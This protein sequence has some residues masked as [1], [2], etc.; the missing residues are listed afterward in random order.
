MSKSSV[1]LTQSPFI[2]KI[3]L[4]KGVLF[5]KASFLSYALSSG[6]VV[7]ICSTNPIT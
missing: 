6:F 3:K 1:F 5:F 7:D 2:F 4:K